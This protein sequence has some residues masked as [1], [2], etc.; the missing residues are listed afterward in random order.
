MVA[1]KVVYD[2]LEGRLNLVVFTKEKKLHKTFSML[3]WQLT[4]LIVVQQ[5]CSR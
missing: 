3:L 5:S 4:Q 1:G 2:V